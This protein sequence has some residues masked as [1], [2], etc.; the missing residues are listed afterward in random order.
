MS[1]YFNKEDYILSGVIGEFLKLRGENLVKSAQNPGQGEAYPA[2]F[3]QYIN[4]QLNNV[5]D[6]IQNRLNLDRSGTRWT[7]Y[8][9]IPLE[10]GLFY[11]GG[12]A[13]FPAIYGV[14]ALRQGVEQS[15]RGIIE[16]GALRGAFDQRYTPELMQ[17]LMRKAQQYPDTTWLRGD[18]NNL[19]VRNEYLSRLHQPDKRAAIDFDKSS[20]NCDKIKQSILFSGR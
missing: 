3:N 12:L 18:S 17:E 2:Q 5:Y 9:E 1:K 16:G 7:R 14:E 11:F 4:P 10:M 8:P 13:G 19:Q 20:I 6:Q 15:H